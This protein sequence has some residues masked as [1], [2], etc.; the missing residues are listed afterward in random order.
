M[1]KRWLLIPISISLI[2]FIVGGVFYFNILDLNSSNQIDLNVS[3][4]QI[5]DRQLITA[6]DGSKNSKKLSF[7]LDQYSLN[8]LFIDS[9]KKLGLND[10]P[11]Y[12]EI[13]ED[14][15]TFFFNVDYGIIRSRIKI[16]TSLL[17][18]EDSFVFKINSI[19]LGNLSAY[20]L[21]NNGTLANLRLEDVFIEAGLNISVDYANSEFKYLKKDVQTD[22]TKMLTSKE[23]ELFNEIVSS[24]DYT[25]SPFKAVGD[26]SNLIEN[27][28][29]S[30]SSPNSMHYI[31]Y[32]SML[33]NVDVAVHELNEILNSPIVNK[34]EVFLKAADSY[35][36]RLRKVFPETYG[37]NEIVKHNIFSR[38]PSQYDGGGYSYEV[39][40]VTEDQ[41]TSFLVTSNIIGKNYVFH[42]ENN[43]FYLVID[44]FY[45]D[46]YS[47]ELGD[48]FISYTMGINLN[49]V[50]TRAIIETQAYPYPNDFITDFEINNIYYGSKVASESFGDLIFDF[51]IDAI[52][53]MEDNSWF[54]YNRD[55]KTIAID[56]STMIKSDPDLEG[57]RIVFYE[58]EG[59]KEMIINE[60]TVDES[61]SFTL[62]YSRD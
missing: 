3:K 34:E 48:T 7:E 8:E 31:A 53:G 28:A 44:N 47:N 4:Q 50:E 27:K 51:F 22:L 62:R 17:N 54:T 40:N 19:N 42:Y 24:F 21:A 32:P 15:Y 25:Y 41:I 2:A 16:Y 52:K 43:L 9:T 14:K 13:N 46:I 33:E 1:K 30:D 59:K 29:I 23:N 5:I 37:L 26:Y 20:G 10:Y 58:N 12:V 56:F 60:N 61:G 45:A 39:A 36:G 35:F 38:I 11:V 57:Y 49:G 6:F 55:N 18:E